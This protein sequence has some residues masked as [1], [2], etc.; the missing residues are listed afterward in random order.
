M[1]SFLLLE[2]RID[3][4]TPNTEHQFYG[5][6]FYELWDLPVRIASHWGYTAS[7]SSY[8][9]AQ[10]FRLQPKSYI[11]TRDDHAIVRR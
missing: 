5:T 11:S 6:T 4:P 9:T 3:Q 1:I 7:S 8:D 10:D 2:R